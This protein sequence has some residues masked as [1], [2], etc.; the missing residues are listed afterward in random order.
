[1][2]YCGEVMTKNPVFCLADD[3]VEIAAGVMKEEQVGPV[4]IVQDEDSLKVIG[5]VTDRDLVLRVLA[6]KRDPKNTTI[7]EVMTKKL[8]S[9]KESDDLESAMKAMSDHQIRRIPVVD[10]KDQLV[11]KL[12]ERYGYSREQA[13]R[14]YSEWERANE[15]AARGA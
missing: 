13:E 6:E 12:Q 3:N 15:H 5:I 14:E 11:G 9:C 8:I 10:K 7:G 1:M 4:P 2:K